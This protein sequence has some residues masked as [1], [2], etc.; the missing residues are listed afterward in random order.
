MLIDLLR[1]ITVMRC[2]RCKYADIVL[3]HCP[4]TKVVCIIWSCLFN[5]REET[6]VVWEV[7]TI[8]KWIHN[9]FCFIRLL[10]ERE[11]VLYCDLHGHSRKQNVF[12]YGCENRGDK[13]KRLHERIFP[14]MLSKNCPDKVSYISGFH[15]V[16][17]TL[18]WALTGIWSGTHSLI[19]MP[20][21]LK[22]SLE[23]NM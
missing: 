17:F 4:N 21:T 23:T 9:H 12:I 11:V 14:A 15:I 8:L 1:L 20:V 18:L 13:S 10:M 22:A 5:V 2:I 6:T 16:W 7:M 19:R 3:E